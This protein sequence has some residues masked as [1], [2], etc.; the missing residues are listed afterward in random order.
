M[1]QLKNDLFI[2]ALQRKEIERTP[3]WIMRQAGR[4]M[5]EYRALRAQ[6]GDFLTLCKNPELA[7]AVTLM[8]VRRFP[9]DAAIIFSDIL[10]IPEAMG[11][12][13]SFVADEGPKFA[14]VISNAADVASLPELDPEEDLGYL[15]D[16]IRLT[17]KELD[18]EIPLIG[19]AGSP[20]TV[21]TYMVE[22]QT[23]KQFNKIRA[24]M[25][26]S[27]DVMHKLLAH[28]STQIANVLL[29]QI[30]A[31]VSTV[32]VFDTW[33]GI[34]SDQLYREFSLRYMQE[35]VTT[36]R[37]IHATIPIILFTKNGG[38]C[39]L[40]IAATG[41]TAIGLDW[42]ANLNASRELVGN[43]VALQGNLDPCVLYAHPDT[44]VA[45]VRETLSQYGTGSGHVFN[46]GHGI[47]PDVNPEHVQV[48]L[49]AVK[50]YSPDFHKRTAMVGT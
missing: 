37:N 17:V 2:R 27:P 6:S 24:M 38:R 36:I 19:F 44:I 34:L 21:A 12:G 33:G 32:M 30:D 29:A 25:Y 15:C 20:W 1:V 41:C 50:K 13:L 4:Y 16:A 8:P 10:L 7:C 23:S 48:L 49:D 11:L 31:G 3:V 46:L 47:P 42:T 5:P 14:S 39:L 40:D 45:R 43:K 9:L 22:G 26:Q 18:N 28:L 35:I